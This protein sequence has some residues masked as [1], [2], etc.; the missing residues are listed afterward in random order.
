MHQNA[1]GVAGLR[2][3]P[4]GELTALPRPPSWINGEEEGETWGNRRQG[5]EGGEEG[6]GRTPNVWSALTPMHAG[7]PK[8]QDRKMTTKSQGGKM[9]ISFIV[10]IL[11][12]AEYLSFSRS[13][14]F[15]SLIFFWFVIFRSCKFSDPINAQSV[16]P[17]VCMSVTLVH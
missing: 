4:L 3:G 15:Q 14:V 10:K 13:C 11:S 9:H 5:E 2:P 1:F 16:C 12:K 7:R 6:K 8:M 17:S